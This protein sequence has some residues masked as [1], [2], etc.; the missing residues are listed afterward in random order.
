M[1]NYGTSDNCH[2]LE[3]YVLTFQRF[4]EDILQNTLAHGCPEMKV[5][6]NMIVTDQGLVCLLVHMRVMLEELPDNR[7]LLL[8]LKLLALQPQTMV[9]SN[10]TSV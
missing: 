6:R 8:T 9:V 2:I 4:M 1:C 3:Y 5:A 7:T 10:F